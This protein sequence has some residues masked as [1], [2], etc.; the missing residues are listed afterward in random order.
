MYNRDDGRDGLKIYTDPDYFFNLW[1]E[2]M[3]KEMR[4]AKEKRREQ[5][6][7]EVKYNV[8]SSTFPSW[9]SFAENL[10]QYTLALHLYAESVYIK[11][12]DAIVLPA[13]DSAL[14][15]LKQSV[16]VSVCGGWDHQH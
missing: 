4:D 1:R 11:V 9:S 8:L 15:N 2:A 12:W 16:A 14:S 10:I 7:K 13:A 3:Q 5:R 6:K